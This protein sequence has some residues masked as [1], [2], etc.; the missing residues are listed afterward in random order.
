MNIDMKEQL[1]RVKDSYEK[2]YYSNISSSSNAQTGHDIVN[3][4]PEIAEEIVHLTTGAPEVHQ[5]L[6]PQGDMRFLD[7]GCNGD[8]AGYN[9]GNW[10]SLYYGVDISAVFIGSMKMY[11]RTNKIRIGELVVSE[12]SN[13]PFEDDF[14]E[15]AAC[16]GVFEYC[17]F[18]YIEKSFVELSRCLK[19]KGKLVVNLPNQEHSLI[20]DLLELENKLERPNYVHAASD[21]ETVVQRNFKIVEADKSRF[22]ATY[23]LRKCG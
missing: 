14:F 8:L 12:I 4:Y 10:P 20:H 2:Q 7:A 21:F 22:L 5:F 1:K 23:Y 11:A 15:I 13:M 19:H 16:I 6:N 17:S 3:Q 18:D 9:L